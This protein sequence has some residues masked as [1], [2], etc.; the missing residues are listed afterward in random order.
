MT[1][2]IQIYNIKTSLNKDF[3]TSEKEVDNFLE[4]INGLK[5]IVFDF[6]NLDDIKK[7]KDLKT[8]ANKSVKLLKE[9]C[10]PYEA[11]GKK[12]ADIR[13]K[14]STTFST[15]KDNI[16]DQILKPIN[17]AEKK[18]KEVKH[19]DI[20]FPNIQVIDYKL[21]EFEELYNFNWLALKD[22]AIHILKSLKETALLKRDLLIKEE[23]ERLKKEE[24]IRKEREDSIRKEAE[25][26]ARIDADN[27]IKR[28]L[29]EKER[30]LQF[31]KQQ[32]E[33]KAKKLTE[34]EERKANNIEHKRKIHNEILDAISELSDI[35]NIDNAKS[36]ICK[37]A[38]GE[39]P[40][41]YI[42]Y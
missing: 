25:E 2:E 32:D 34:E 37:I 36:L 27:R 10:E 17:D 4:Q 6:N 13:S 22:E 26:K 3:I 20:T 35:T 19:T 9:V 28:E 29:E 11:E 18:L 38:K 23:A 12:I 5:D 39:I 24:K 15:G 1:N 41:L 30:V 16:I 40:H 33:L 31:Q 7:A 14:I 21:K 8:Q 42:K